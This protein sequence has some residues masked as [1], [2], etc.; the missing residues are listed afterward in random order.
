MFDATGN[1]VEVFNGRSRTT[2]ASIDGRD[3]FFLST[4]LNDVIQ[5]EHQAGNF[6]EQEELQLIARHTTPGMAFCDIGANVGNH[7]IFFGLFL[8]PASI[9]C[10]EPN[11]E[12][13][14]A[15]RANIFL[16]RL[17]DICDMSKLG[18][19]LG[20]HERQNA[21]ISFRARN[22]GASRISDGGG[23]IQICTGDAL[24]AGDKIDFLKIDVEGME[25]EVLK[26][27]SN[28]LERYAPKIFIEVQNEN[29]AAVDEYLSAFNY[30]K[31]EE[32]RR[33]PQ[34]INFLYAPR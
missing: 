3:V 15:L 14:P 26:G 13:L 4:H 34:N 28:T 12:V 6:Y 29:I 11:P 25:L 5:K 27:F 1:T 7:T 22:T 2:R 8:Q 19:A 20:S 23:S 10:I 32:W 30:T 33:Y 16:N 17:D 24:L 31:V 18:L 9:M 21:S